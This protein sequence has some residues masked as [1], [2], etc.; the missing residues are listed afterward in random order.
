MKKTLLEVNPRGLARTLRRRGV[1]AKAQVMFELVSNAFDQNVIAVK[2]VLEKQRAPMVMISVEDDDPAGFPALH[3]AYELFGESPKAGNAEKRGRFD[4]GEKLV[5]SLC[6]KA[7]ISTTKGTVE[8]DTKNN[9]RVEY[10]L[11]KRKA[12][13]IF[14]GWIKMEP[15][16]F[17]ACCAAVKK[18]LVPEGVTATFNGEVLPRRQPLKIFNAKLPTEFSDESGEF[19]R[20]IRNTVVWVLEPEADEEPTLYEMGIPVV[21]TGDRWHVCIGQRVPLNVERDNVTPAYLKQIRTLVVNEMR[22]KLDAEISC[23]PLVCA[24]LESPDI[25]PEA[26]KAILEARY[27]LPLDKIAIADPKEPE[28]TSKAIA[29]GYGVIYGNQFSRA[30]WDQVRKLDLPTTFDVAPVHRLHLSGDGEDNWVP[31]EKWSPG[32]KNM[33][34]FARALGHRL[35]GVSISV[36]ILNNIKESC[37]AAFG[38]RSLT[39]NLGRLGHKWFD[40]PILPAVIDLYIHEFGHHICGNHL[41]SKYHDALSKMAGEVC[42]MALDDPAFFHRHFPIAGR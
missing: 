30:Q 7:E 39:L 29:E 13:S 10:P 5:I 40:Q 3:H 6:E 26:T 23:T 8:F 31:E 14:T 21:G 12:G 33:V 9:T 22:D 25:L 4:I 1:D 19:R 32:M 37:S 28:S 34:E 16:E 41:D 27:E 11:K 42:Q 38:S 2:I 36:K 18:V 24:A 35:L 15:E 17:D 20:S